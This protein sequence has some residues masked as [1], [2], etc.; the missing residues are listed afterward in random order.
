MFLLALGKLELAKKCSI[1]LL[2]DN[3][4]VISVL[5][6]ELRV[7]FDPK[8]TFRK[9]KSNLYYTRD[10]TPKRVA[11]GGVHLPSL[12]PGQHRN[13]AVVATRWRHSVRFDQPGI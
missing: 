3:L 13:V 2:L 5:L 9:S 1:W 7:T 6:N 8:N 10:I 11:S 4:V 12:V